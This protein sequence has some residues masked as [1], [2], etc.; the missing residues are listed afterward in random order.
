[1]VVCERGRICVAR[2]SISFHAIPEENYWNTWQG[3]GGSGGGDFPEN[4]LF[5][6]VHN[7]AHRM[8]GE[9]RQKDTRKSQEAISYANRRLTETEV[10]K[11]AVEEEEEEGAKTERWSWERAKKSY[12]SL[13]LLLSFR[14]FLGG[15]SPSLS[16]SLTL[17]V[18]TH[19]CSYCWGSRPASQIDRCLRGSGI[20]RH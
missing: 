9:G 11:E 18:R 16:L 17:L 6:L 10:F 2:P 5:R 7:Y 3:G 14:G 4:C 8:A 1:M 19:F 12:L 13:F 15:P 20:R